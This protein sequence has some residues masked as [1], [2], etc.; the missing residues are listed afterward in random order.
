MNKIICYEC[1]EKGADRFF[2]FKKSLFHKT[3]K[4]CSCNK[5]KK[6]LLLREINEQRKKREG[7]KCPH[8]DT[9]IESLNYTETG[10]YEHGSFSLETE[11]QDSDG[12]EWDGE[13][14]THYSCPDCGDEITQAE[15]EA[16]LDSMKID[17]KS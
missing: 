7:P 9:E 14:I 11:E 12:T 15:K 13:G 10:Y 3:G 17:N 8:C 4:C 6:G 16:I 1:L 5:I 2:S